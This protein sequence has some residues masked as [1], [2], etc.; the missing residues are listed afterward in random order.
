MS[1][2]QRPILLDTSTDPRPDILAA[3]KRT[4]Y[5]PSDEVQEVVR[6]ILNAVRNHGDE[7]LVNL[8]QEF[9]KWKEC[10]IEGLQVKDEEIEAAMDRV[11]PKVM[12][13]LQV[14]AERL[15]A[16]HRNQARKSW[17]M[18]DDAGS[19]LGQQVTP[20]ESVGIY[21]PGGLATYPSSILHAGIPARVAG[22]PQIFI[23][24]PPSSDG[25]IPPTVLAA[26][27][28]VGAESIFKAGGAQAMA[29]F[30]FGTCVFPAVHKLAGPGG[31]H[32]VVAKKLLYGIVGIDLLPGPSEIYVIADEKA[33]VKIVAA[34]LIAQ[35]EHS[36]DSVVVLLTPS[37]VLA[38]A[39]HAEINNCM[40]NAPRHALI[41]EALSTRGAIIVTQGLHEA[42]ELCNLGAPEHVSVLVED[43][44]PL[45]PEL[46]NAGAIFVG[47]HSPVAAGDYL[48]GPSHVLPTAGTARFASGISVDAFVRTTSLIRLSETALNEI[49][50]AIITLAESEGL[51]AHAD[52][53]R[54]RQRP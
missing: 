13:A 47:I 48:A 45:L 43:P 4:T 36:G 6:N 37:N 28:M 51:P 29:A 11:P 41:S 24:T 30:A 34:D 1:N 44:E 5:G 35:A 19:E 10:K 38:Q 7:A 16:F 46:H 33:P 8:E 52:S 39:V 14:A 25:T 31:I 40:V 3:L 22:V 50:D 54:R 42:V 18:Q 17:S 27:R 32:T 2:R 53:V 21:A 26:A 20:I 12:A 9:G 23:A 15:E 49:S